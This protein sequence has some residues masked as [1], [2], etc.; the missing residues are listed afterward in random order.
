[1]SRRTRSP[2]GLGDVL[3]LRVLSA[4][5]GVPILLLL[6]LVGGSWYVAAV[7]GGAIAATFEMSSML[8]GAGFRPARWL[9]IGLTVAI[10]LDAL[11]GDM[12]VLP[13]ILVVGMLVGML[14]MMARPDPTGALVD[15]ALTL[16]PAI[17]VGGTMHYLIA[18]RWLPDG[19]LW[20][21][22]V[23]VCTW[24][25]DITA[26]FVGRR[27][28]RI[29]LAPRLSP[30]KSVEGAIGGLVGAV[31]AAFLIGP[32]L[33][34]IMLSLGLPVR[35]PFGGWQMLGFG[36]VIGVC[37]IAGDLMESFIKRQCGAKDS[38]ALIPGHG[39][40]LDRI[41]SVLLAVV[42]AYFYVVM[43]S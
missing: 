39:G 2:T 42:G 38:G 22:L 4:F 34:G 6:A 32:F 29:K 3:R 31:L 14:Q 1:V 36:L 41:D 8:A 30:A 13:A 7:V 19:L 40:V 10:V 9:A 11:T 33:V 43:T 20:I 23:L 18:L 5:I 17:Y 35:G 26:F 21:L 16:A 15:W 25:C 28:G 24:A 12:R 27:W 37:A